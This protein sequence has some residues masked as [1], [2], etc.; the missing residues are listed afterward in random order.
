MLEQTTSG[1][2]CSNDGIVH[3]TLPGLP[4]GGIGKC[5]NV[6]VVLFLLFFILKKTQAISLDYMISFYICI[7][8]FS[9]SGQISII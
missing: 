7:K 4:F 2:F 8:I 3:M 9:I 6:Q 1:G 5:L